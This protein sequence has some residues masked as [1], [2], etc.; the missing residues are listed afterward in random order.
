[1]MA[2]A[3]SSP[4]TSSASRIGWKVSKTIIATDQK[5]ST[6]TMPRSTRLVRSRPRPSRTTTGASFADASARRAPEASR[7]S[8]SR[9]SRSSTRTAS[10]CTTLR[11]TK[12]ATGSTSADAP[13]NGCHQTRP[14]ETRAPA[15][16]LPP[17]TVPWAASAPS[18][19]APGVVACT[20][21]T[22]HASSGTGV[23]RP[24]DAGEHGRGEEGP[25]GVRDEQDAARDDVDDGGDDE[26]RAAAEGVGEAA[27][28]QLE[29]EDRQAG[30]GR[31]GHRLCDGEAALELPQGEQPDDEPDGEPAGE[32]QGEEDPACGGGG[33]DGIRPL[34][35]GHQRAPRVGG[36]VEVEGVGEGVDR[37]APG[38]RVA[39]S[40]PA[41]ALDEV[42]HLRAHLLRATRR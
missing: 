26:D 36:S 28:R 17:R 25:E 7:C 38:L 6:Q 8:A 12:T 20:V 4:P 16:M 22:N 34:G 23:E 15:A 42:P 21:S 31:D 29:R 9:G 1:M 27:R 3:R 2:P 24:E 30:G 13:M 5:T 37:D 35:G 41:V 11:T 40:D 10:R 32:G 19:S 39:L 18:T 14:P 33:E